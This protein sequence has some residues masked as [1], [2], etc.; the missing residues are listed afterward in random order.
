[1]SAAEILIAVVGVSASI[2][3]YALM[4]FPHTRR[5]QFRGFGT[6]SVAASAAGALAVLLFSLVLVWAQRSWQGVEP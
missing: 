2:T 6:C 3:T 4:R 5:E 1:M